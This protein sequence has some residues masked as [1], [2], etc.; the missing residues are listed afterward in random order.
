MDITSDY[1]AML[2]PSSTEESPLGHAAKKMP[3]G[4]GKPAPHSQ[5]G[6]I[7]LWTLAIIGCI[8]S[9]P[10]AEGALT[11]SKS[12]SGSAALAQAHMTS[13]DTIFRGPRLADI[14]PSLLDSTSDASGEEQSEPLAD[15]KGKK[16]AKGSKSQ[17]PLFSRKRRG[18]GNSKGTSQENLLGT[19]TEES[20]A[21]VNS[22]TT[23]E[24][25]SEP[26]GEG[27]GN[28]KKK[29]LLKIKTPSPGKKKGKRSSKGGSREA[30][31]SPEGEENGG[32]TDNSS[33]ELN[34]FWC[35]IPVSE[36][37]PSESAT[38]G[39]D[40]KKKGL[41]RPKSTLGKK[42]RGK[43]SPLSTSQKNLPASGSDESDGGAEQPK[44]DVTEEIPAEGRKKKRSILK[45]LRSKRPRRGESGKQ[46]IPLGVVFDATQLAQASEIGREMLGS[47]AASATEQKEVYEA[48]EAAT[49]DGDSCLKFVADAEKEKAG[50]F[51]HELQ[52]A[53][54]GLL[55]YAAAE[56]L[57][58]DLKQLNGITSPPTPGSTVKVLDDVL[59]PSEPVFT[60]QAVEGQMASLEGFERTV[61]VAKLILAPD[62]VE[63]GFVDTVLNASWNTLEGEDP[64]VFT[65]LFD[66]A[67]QNGYGEALE[68]G[69]KTGNFSGLL[70][71]LNENS[72]VFRVVVGIRNMLGAPVPE[73]PAGRQAMVEILQTV[74]LQ[75]A[76]PGCLPLNAVSLMM[77]P[78]LLFARLL[79]RFMAGSPLLGPVGQEIADNPVNKAYVTPTASPIQGIGRHDQLRSQCMAGIFAELGLNAAAVENLSCHS[80]WKSEQKV[81]GRHG[82]SPPAHT[83]SLLMR[84]VC[85]TEDRRKRQP[86][87][88]PVGSQSSCDSGSL[89]K[90]SLRK[91]WANKATNKHRKAYRLTPHHLRIGDALRMAAFYSSDE[92]A[93][94]DRSV[95]AAWLVGKQLLAVSREQAK[96]V[97][98]GISLNAES[99]AGP[100]PRTEGKPHQAES[101]VSGLSPAAPAPLSSEAESASLLEYSKKRPS[102]NPGNSI[103]SDG[104]HPFVVGGNINVNAINLAAT[105]SVC[106]LL[107]ETDVSNPMLFAMDVLTNLR[108]Y[109]SDSGAGLESAEK[110]RKMAKGSD[111]F[112]VMYKCF[113][114]GFGGE[115]L[116]PMFVP[117][118]SL[119]LQVGTFLRVELEESKAVPFEKI[120]HTMGDGVFNTKEHG[121]AVKHL[122]KKAA[123]F[124]EI[125]TPC[126]AE[127]EASDLLMLSPQTKSRLSLARRLN[128]ALKRAKGKRQR[129]NGEMCEISGEHQQLT[130]LLVVWWVLGRSSSESTQEISQSLQDTAATFRG[131]RMAFAFLLFNNGHDQAKLAMEIA[132]AGCKNNKFVVPPN[133]TLG[134]KKG[135]RASSE[136]PF[137]DISK[138]INDSFMYLES[139]LGSRG[140]SDWLLPLRG[141]QQLANACGQQSV[142]QL[143]DLLSTDAGSLILMSHQCIKLQGVNALKITE[144]S[145]GLS[146]AFGRYA[147]S[148]DEA[149]QQAVL[150]Q[151]NGD[152]PNVE[153]PWKQNKR[154]QEA[155]ILKGTSYQ[156]PA[157]LP[158]KAA[159]EAMEFHCPAHAA[160]RMQD[161]AEVPPPA[162]TQFCTGD[163][164]QCVA[165]EYSAELQ[166]R[167]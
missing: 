16:G 146:Q 85:S 35:P 143:A 99:H 119:A 28:K 86:G 153:C 97:L 18:K 39:E 70:H 12:G 21:D 8:D 65:R 17:K 131:A 121:T 42:K 29:G 127:V 157:P 167:L 10:K 27:Q 139:S 116:P 103:A 6:K 31:V 41:K 154:A 144:G 156:K 107:L 155:M 51:P 111:V 120:V 126:M 19:Q 37:H 36:E 44:P 150:A 128:K 145:A 66:F 91:D 109:I 166:S 77:Q 114:C 112:C 72:S 149:D 164:S 138:D 60:V 151:W 117:Y 88:L 132:K 63:V 45:L 161:L 22:S 82:Y 104:V 46:T 64:D 9:P 101:G 81:K 100:L 158:V 11:G 61:N 110:Q 105:A 53:R 152:F 15:S 122:K 129:A 135:N 133:W 74:L 33:T 93:E 115:L 142:V 96:N 94:L 125:F 95:A 147:S 20:E 49:A 136:I 159:A 67:T 24:S 108:G 57:L 43:G 75:H 50:Y 68:T 87:L 102:P 123:R 32:S 59:Q 79:E 118:A 148:S 2:L 124:L 140:V 58:D 48:I 162:T 113:S 25:S 80:Y 90:A 30:L 134:S 47:F 106:R 34:L 78:S 160:L 71:S 38:G 62:P 54:Q 92:V 83:F 56:R 163:S 84:S 137:K 69:R 40:K 13:L 3:R 26:S 89:V 7:I 52:S 5:S 76:F 4:T 130:R 141:A 1:R 55:I 98:A 23:E 14:H 165:F 73:Y